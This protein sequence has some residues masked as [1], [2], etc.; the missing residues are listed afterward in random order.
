MSCPRSENLVPSPSGRKP[1]SWTVLGVTTAVQVL[2]SGSALTPPVF[3]TVAAAEM[4]LD[5][6][7]VGFY[8]SLVYLG[9]MLTSLPSG[10][11]I[12]RFGA[13]RVSQV[14]LALCMA[15][16]V[17]LA[18]AQPLL[19]LVG[20]LLIGFGY[21]PVTPASSHVLARTTP[22]ERRGLVFSLKQTGVPLGGMMAG[23]VVPS[24]VLW[25]GWQ[26][27]SV[28]IGVA[29][30]ALALGVQGVRGGLDGD[31]HRDQALRGAALLGPLAT[32]WRHRPLRLLS[33][34][35]FAFAA[36]QLSLATFLVAY[37]VEDIDLD[38]VTAGLVLSTAQM[39]GVIGRVV[40]GVVADRLLGPRWTL[41]MLAFAMA[42]GAAGVAALTP[43]W[44]VA[45]VI[46]VSAVFGATAVGWNGVY[47]AE[48]AHLA[49]PGEAGKAT[50]AA[51]FF[52]YAGVV[53][54]PSLFG[55]VAHLPGGYPLAFTLCAAAAGVGGVLVLAVGRPRPGL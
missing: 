11:L 15:G 20:A 54:G 38:L 53:C 18:G 40:W 2:I 6:R 24:L 43:D 36:I 30:G 34:A 28:V 26:A 51:L 8:T 12:T 3:A 19:V 1:S 7:T 29:A 46:A 25:L 31:R 23:A 9:A 16:L 5:A 21:G 44:P 33:L 49:P 35:S 22:P 55:L 4:G 42:A 32:V 14:C 37:L 27:A 45:V 52:T 10:S 48:V 17:V 50:G 39:A 47:L 13:M 41:V